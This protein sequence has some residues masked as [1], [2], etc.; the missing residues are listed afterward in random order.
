M[1]A[2]VANEIVSALTSAEERAPS[3][4]ASP[5]VTGVI[6]LDM[7]TSCIE[8]WCDALPSAPTSL[9]MHADIAS[10]LALTATTLNYCQWIVVEKAAERERERDCVFIFE[11]LMRDRFIY[12][13]TLR[14]RAVSLSLNR[15]SI[16]QLH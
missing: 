9:F 12:K 14:G 15:P 6:F 13:Y 7:L 1:H 5:S 8:L 11:L 16:G 2:A 3:R 10:S 4:A